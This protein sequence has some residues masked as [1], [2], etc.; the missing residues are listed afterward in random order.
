ML[1]YRIGL[2]H[3]VGQAGDT[4]RLEA[5]IQSLKSQVAGK[6]SVAQSHCMCHWN[7]RSRSNRSLVDRVACCDCLPSRH[8]IQI[9]AS[10]RCH[11]CHRAILGFAVHRD[12]YLQEIARP[13]RLDLTTDAGS[14]QIEP[15]RDRRCRR[16]AALHLQV[17]Q[18]AVD[19]AIA[20]HPLPCSSNSPATVY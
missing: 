12:C 7:H 4:V 1:V 14:D 3:R 19:R 18:I 9:Q 6:K 20:C 2:S 17:V 16:T 15:D 8:L 10:H 13:Y 5:D 11:H